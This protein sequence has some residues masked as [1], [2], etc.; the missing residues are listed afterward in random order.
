MGATSLREGHL[1]LKLPWPLFLGTS[2]VFEE[3]ASRQQ[4]PSLAAP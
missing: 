2:D 1:C 3:P 4:T